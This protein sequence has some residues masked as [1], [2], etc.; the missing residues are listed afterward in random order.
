MGKKPCPI[1]AVHSILFVSAF[2]P[3]S[4]APLQSDGTDWSFWT[5]LVTCAVSYSHRS[6]LVC[7]G[8]NWNGDW[9]PQY[10]PQKKPVATGNVLSLWISCWKCPS[11]INQILNSWLS[12]SSPVGTSHIATSALLSPPQHYCHHLSITVTTSV[13]TGGSF[14]SGE[15]GLGFS[16]SHIY[17]ASARLQQYNISGPNIFDK[18]LCNISSSLHS[19]AL[20]SLC[21][22]PLQNIIR[23]KT[24]VPAFGGT[25]DLCSG[26]LKDQLKPTNENPC[27]LLSS[28]VVESL[29]ITV[30]LLGSV[31]HTSCSPGPKLWNYLT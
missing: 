8:H 4:L 2:F 20:C 19:P 31:S 11:T 26:Y 14:C 10:H 30:K 13:G 3:H 15:Q 12:D 28:P 17:D 22:F 16:Y 25:S 7:A 1:F 9:C 5:A 23:F 27:Q 6:H 29:T 21:L 24:P 18:W